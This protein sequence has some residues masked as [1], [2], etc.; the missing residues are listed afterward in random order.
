M[1]Q[2]PWNLLESY[3]KSREE[4]LAKV[5]ARKRKC[6]AK[7]KDVYNARRRKQALDCSNTAFLSVPHD[8]KSS[9]PLD[10]S[11]GNSSRS[12]DGIL[13]EFIAQNAKPLDENNILISLGKNGSKWEFTKFQPLDG[14]KSRISSTGDETLIDAFNRNCRPLDFSILGKSPMI[15]HSLIGENTTTVCLVCG[16]SWIGRGSR[17]GAKG[18][19]AITGHKLKRGFE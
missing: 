9:K 6:W 13:L 15:E 8:S 3:D 18:N 10:V 4:Q 19:S 16:K 2:L 12:D 14:T 7:H 1:S 17:W 5:R 11:K